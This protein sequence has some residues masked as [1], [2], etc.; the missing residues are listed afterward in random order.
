MFRIT[1]QRM[2]KGIFVNETRLEI[3]NRERVN[4]GDAI[5]NTATAK[6]LA[7][8]APNP[9]RGATSPDTVTPENY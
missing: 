6:S 2:M 3:T 9:E 5:T 1:I 7:T 8:A 4:P